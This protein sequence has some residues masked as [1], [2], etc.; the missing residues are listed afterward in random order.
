[1][2]G[3]VCTRA[4]TRPGAGWTR[5]VTRT[6]RGLRCAWVILVRGR[7]WRDEGSEAGLV[8]MVEEVREER[9]QVEHGG[10]HVVHDMSMS[11]SW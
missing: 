4:S 11:W 6:R 2:A 3:G 8:D 7:H 9:E 10:V 1:M 5:R